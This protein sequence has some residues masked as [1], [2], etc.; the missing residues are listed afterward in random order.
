MSMSMWVALLVVFM[1]LSPVPRTA[2]LSPRPNPFGVT[3]TGFIPVTIVAFV[4]VVLLLLVIRFVLGIS[5]PPPNLGLL[6]LLMLCLAFANIAIIQLL[7]AVV[8][9]AG[10]LLALVLLMLQLCSCGGTYPVQMQPAFSQAITRV[11]CM[12]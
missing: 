9:S 6:V 11:T 1:L 12:P 7:N 10:R 3:M 2:M 4:Q 5:P 8:G